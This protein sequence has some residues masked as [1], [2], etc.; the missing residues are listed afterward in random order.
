MSAAAGAAEIDL[1][2]AVAGMTLAAAL[3]DDHGAVLLPQ[4]ATLTEATLA[5]LRR[6]GVRRC[7]V[8]ADAD[9][10]DPAVLARERERR[11]QRLERLFRHSGDD[12]GAAALLR[13][14]R[15]HRQRDPA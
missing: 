3:L 10:V 6:R 13:A 12:A 14:L 1:D 2:Q 9:P 15:A 5:S 8:C 11:A 7:L 4:G